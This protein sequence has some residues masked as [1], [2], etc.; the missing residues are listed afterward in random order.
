MNKLSLQDLLNIRDALDMLKRYSLA[1]KVLR[2]KINRELK[3]RTKGVEGVKGGE[4][5]RHRE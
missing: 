4:D 5:L 3:K 1:D 2:G